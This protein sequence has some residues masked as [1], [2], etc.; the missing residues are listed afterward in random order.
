MG[1]GD[2]DSSSKPE[3]SNVG[4]SSGVS[5]ESEEDRK[6][7][8]RDSLK[9]FLES[10]RNSMDKKDHSKQSR[11][12]R[13]MRVV[14]SVDEWARD[15]L[16]DDMKDY[17]KEM[18]PGFES[19]YKRQDVSN[20][21]DKNEQEVMRSFLSEPVDVVFSSA[22]DGPPVGG[23]GSTTSPPPS[24]PLA[25]TPAA[26]PL[27]NSSD[28]STISNTDKAGIGPTDVLDF[29]NKFWI[30]LL[31]GFLLVA[32]SVFFI[33]RACSKRNSRHVEELAELR[34]A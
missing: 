31:S 18:K 3:R 5:H 15:V 16:P 24:P 12:E 21:A 8:K 30:F 1:K 32:A 17:W 28:S 4:T 34:R 26:A 25:P 9:P 19:W 14:S 13:C 11:D 20:T 6:K 7:H 2:G 23:G 33:C 10:I 22:G 29:V 27:G